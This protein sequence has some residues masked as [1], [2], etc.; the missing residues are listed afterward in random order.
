[1][2]S[3]TPSDSSLESGEWNG[4]DQ[5]FYFD[6]HP[7][8]YESF[9]PDQSF[10]GYQYLFTKP[11]I[12][13]AATW[14]HAPMEPLGSSSRLDYEEHEPRQQQRQ[15]RSCFNCGES[16]HTVAQCPKPKDHERIRQSRLEFEESK[17]PRGNDDDDSGEINGHARLHEQ[18]AS[19]KQRLRWLDEFVP[20]KPSQALIEALLPETDDDGWGYDERGRRNQGSSTD[21][22]YLHRMLVWGYPPGWIAS[23]DPIEQIRQRIQNDS[24]W[25]SVEVLAGFDV[26]ALDKRHG[27]Q[28]LAGG[29]QTTATELEKEPS[30]GEAMKRWVDYQTD[31]F[32]SYRLQSFDT[33]FRAPLP[34]MQQRALPSHSHDLERWS[35]RMHDEGER[36][37]NRPLDHSSQ[38]HEV[39]ERAA[40]WERLLRERFASPP[41]RHSASEGAVRRAPIRISRPH[42]YAPPPSTDCVPASQPPP[43][44]PIH[45]H[46]P[47]SY[48]APQPPPSP[49]PPPPPPCPPPALPPPP[50]V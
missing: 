3:P 37:R 30:A 39:D 45:I 15:E 19:A 27:L 33:M 6:T 46:R 41:P 44:T 2:A 16:D 49:P 11:R 14:A 24:Q 5:S 1:M 47:H 21:L 40:L 17:A 32:D 38:K 8:P 34:Q 9:D 18:F 42:P 20:G 26:T 43:R 4:E 31:L 29:A 23:K 22:P 28:P 12:D 13:D 35:R 10:E 7:T 25:D 36:L 50:P 48:A